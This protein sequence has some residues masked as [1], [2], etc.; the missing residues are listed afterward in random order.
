MGC[1]LVVP[2]PVP[3]VFLVRNY[4]RAA[5]IS[6]LDWDLD[7]GRIARQALNVPGDPV[8]VFL[9]TR[10]KVSGGWNAEVVVCLKRLLCASA[11]RAAVCS[12]M[13]SEHSMFPLTVMTP[14]RS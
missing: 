2:P 6:S 12:S 7:G 10:L 1:A 9:R 11:A 4:V 13:R 5:Q 3:M 8:A 14:P